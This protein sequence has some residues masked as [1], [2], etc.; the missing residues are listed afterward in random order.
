MTEGNGL[1]TGVDVL[2]RK[3]RTNVVVATFKERMALHGILTAHLHRVGDTRYWVYEEG[4]DD[5]RVL[6]EAGLPRLNTNHVRGLR[7][8]EFGPTR[9]H[10]GPVPGTVPTDVVELRKQL[11]TLTDAHNRLCAALNNAGLVLDGTR[12]TVELFARTVAP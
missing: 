5:A 4:W 2:G 7:T 8:D 11:A 9:P 12:F 3:S 10:T 1:D 6:A